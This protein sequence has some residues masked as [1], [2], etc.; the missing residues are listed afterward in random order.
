MATAKR[1]VK[2]EA[3]GSSG[4][5]HPSSARAQKTSKGKAT[6]MYDRYQTEE[7][8]DVRQASTRTHTKPLVW[9]RVSACR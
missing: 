2:K 3:A 9:P 8:T 7:S 4:R 6:A 5:P 1:R